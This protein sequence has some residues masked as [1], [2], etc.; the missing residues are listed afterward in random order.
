MLKLT[1]TILIQERTECMSLPDSKEPEGDLAFTGERFIPHQ[2]DPL[3]A[4]E[5]YHRYYFASRLASGKKVLD[6]ACGEG[7]G[8]AFL[9]KWAGSV[10]GIDIDE[11]T[12]RHAQ[13][14]YASISNLSFTAGPCEDIPEDADSFD[15]VVS[16]ELLE[17]LDSDHQVRFVKN[18]QR[19]LKQNG[20]FV[21]SSPERYEYAAT[22]QAANEFHKHELTLVELQSFLG[23]FFRHVYLCA[24]R[25]L[26]LSTIWQLQ[27][28]KD[29][30]FRFQSRKDL[31]EEIPCSES[32]SP[33][34]YLIAI[35]SNDPIPE[36]VLAET[37]SVYFDTSNS[38]Q[39]KNFSRW[40]LQLDA[41]VQ[42]GREAIRDYQRQLE[43]FGRRMD[44]CLEEHRQQMDERA[45]WARNLE[46][47]VRGQSEFIDMLKKEL[48][49]RTQWALSLESELARER[50]KLQASM[51]ELAKIRTDVASSLM[52]RVLSKIKLLPS[53]W[54]K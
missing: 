41:E 20:L 37:N 13:T 50:N 5:H 6:I 8:S 40:A 32:F 39:T 18:V 30:R 46:S 38:D 9:S 52:Y 53:V 48:E 35:C 16:F 33:P 19:V 7:Y 10:T 11:A 43:E 14:K 36:E 26:C 45:A 54:T 3:L 12:V 28:W 25:V 29:A 1:S 4:L 44:G 21:L 15:V 47:Q 51:Q 42:T 34:L 27:N 23:T 49:G 24:Q 22:Y 2:T 17:H 31:M